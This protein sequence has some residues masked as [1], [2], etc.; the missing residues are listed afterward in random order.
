VVGTGGADKHQVAFMIARLLPAAGA[1]VADAADA[2][3]V[4]IAHAHA[5]NRPLLPLREKVSAKPTDE[6]SRR[7]GRG[8]PLIRPYGPPFP[9]RGE[10]FP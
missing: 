7:P 2:L 1:P 10:G 5:R 8:K 3:A 9:A 4:A 6:G